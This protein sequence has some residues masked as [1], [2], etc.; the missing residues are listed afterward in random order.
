MSFTPGVPVL[1]DAHDGDAARRRIAG[2]PAL[3]QAGSD[4]PLRVRY[5]QAHHLWIECC[6]AEQVRGK[7][8]PAV[9]RLTLLWLR[10]HRGGTTFAVSA[11][12]RA[13]A[14]S[15]CQRIV[16]DMPKHGLTGFPWTPF[17]PPFGCGLIEA[18][19]PLR[20]LQGGALSPRALAKGSSKI[21]PSMD[22]PDFL[23]LLFDPPLA[24]AS[25]RPRHLCGLI[26]AALPL[27]PHRGRA[28][29]AA[30]SRPR[31]LGRFGYPASIR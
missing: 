10:P 31:H 29:S 28:T 1:A 23:G 20:S 27:R 4:T 25:S 2:A 22:L 15:A 24:A 11:R 17:W 16:K 18:A 7:E 3:R 14:E 8:N 21:C 19:P 30:S 26:E 9:R 5:I 12:W 13:L 6:G